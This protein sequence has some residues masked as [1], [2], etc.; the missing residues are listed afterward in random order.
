MLHSNYE[1]LGDIYAKYGSLDLKSDYIINMIDTECSNFLSMR[2]F[3][4][5]RDILNFSYDI[6]YDKSG[7]KVT[8][9]AD[10]ILCALWFIGVFPRDCPTTLLEN[11]FESKEFIYTFDENT[12]KLKK[13]R[14]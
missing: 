1:S 6:R 13:K 2:L 7:D 9:V 8:I 12:C 11:R 5:N 3:N 14:K 4:F 10:N